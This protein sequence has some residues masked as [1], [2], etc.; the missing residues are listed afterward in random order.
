MKV[1][2][3]CTGN[4]C[5]SPIA[6]GYLSAQNLPNVTAESRGLY[7]DG[8]PISQ[9]SLEVLR[10]IGIDMHEHLSKPLTQDDCDTADLIIC[11]S[12]GHL[13]A[14]LQAGVP[15]ERLMLL[16]EGIPDPFGGNLTVYRSCRDS[17]TNA[18]D[19]LI[20]SGTFT[21]FSIV[22]PDEKYMKQIAL[23]E[24]ECFSEPWSE[25]ALFES[26]KAGT[27]FLIA[28]KDEKV[29]G[30]VG[31]NMILDEGYITNVAVTA[32]ARRKG[33]AS[34]LMS[35]LLRMGQKNGLSFISLEVRAS[36]NPAISL[37]TKFGFK[38]EGERRNF[39]RN[40][41]ENAIIMTKRFDKINEDFE[42]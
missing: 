20:K 26:F 9:N 22:T 42:H 35:T 18:I 28:A 2:F 34:F 31:I 8:S 5:R 21:P 39:Y 11:L 12:T 16:S 19:E 30:Y 36:N 13:Y 27:K 29:L 7:A 17:I 15:K 38:P 14:L 3:V 4:T 24:N 32:A 23:L 6:E 40:P 25:N 1:I 37:Y 41:V 33:V 10:E